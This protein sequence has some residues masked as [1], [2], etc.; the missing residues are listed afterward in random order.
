MP[1]SQSRFFCLLAAALLLPPG[2]AAAQSVCGPVPAANAVVGLAALDIGSN[3]TAN[4][5]AVARGVFQQDAIAPSGALVT[6]SLNLP[7]L[8]P[9]AFPAINFGTTNSSGPDIAAGT[10]NT[11]TVSGA[12]TR[13]TG[14]GTYRIGN[15]TLQSGAAA[16]FAPGEYFVN[17][18]TTA[19]GVSLSVS[20]PGVVR[21]YI[22][23]ALDIGNNSF[24]NAG[25]DPRNMQF[26]LYSPTLARFGAANSQQSPVS[27]VVYSPFSTNIQIGNNTDFTGAIVTAGTV[28]LGTRVNLIY[29]SAVQAA[30]AEVSSCALPPVQPSLASRFVIV[31]DG[32]GINC[33]AEPVTV[34]AVDAAGAVVT[35]YA[36][37]VTL[38]TST[39]RGTWSLVTGAGAFS[40]AT[41]DDG[42]ATYAFAAADRGQAAFTLYAPQGGATDIDASDG[43]AADNDSEGLLAFRPYGFLITPAPVG[44]RVAGRPFNL[45][46][47]AAGQTRSDPQCGVIEA[48]AG[49]RTLAFWSEYVNPATGTR[50]VS[51]NGV[52]AATSSAAATPQNVTF[53]AG[54]ASIAASY[55]DAGSLRLFVR[56]DAGIGEPPAGT[57]GEIIDEVTNVLGA[58]AAF[59]VRPFGLHVAATGNPAATG[60]TGPRF[61][62][63]GE[64]FDVTATGKVWAAADDANNDG[65][66]DGHTDD[67]PDNNASLADNATTPNFGLATP[68]PTVGRSAVLIDPNPN[69]P[70]FNRLGFPGILFGPTSTAYASGVVTLRNLLYTDVGIIELQATVNNY[71]STG[72]AIHGRSG[73]VGRFYPHQIVLQSAS[74]TP[75]CGGFTYMDQPALGVAFA[76]RATSTNIYAAPPQILFNYHAGTGYASAVVGLAAENGNAG[77][78]LG[79]RLSFPAPTWDRGSYTVNTASAA[80]ARAAAPDGPFE[81]LILGARILSERDN[82]PLQNR[83]MNPATTGNC[84]TTSSCTARMLS[85]AGTRLRYG[86][87]VADN[88]QGS[89]LVPLPLPLRAEYFD[90]NG[91]IVNVADNC[92]PYRA[93]NVSFVPGSYT[94]GLDPGETAPALATDPGALSSGQ[95]SAT[96]ALRLTAPGAGNTGSVGFIYDAPAWLHFDWN[97]VDEGNDGNLYDD[98]PG[99]RATFG[100]FRGPERLIYRRELY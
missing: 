47:T 46:L 76:L 62:K 68:S 39:N 56:D 28:T 6:L 96:N 33:L 41:P 20:P 83:D 55:P 34:R 89:E 91:Y 70:D 30:V 7:G 60:P 100:V 92:T 72:E 22:N 99:G 61:R 77:V 27:A 86:R 53:T 98:D 42:R 16:Q 82:T 25:G 12:S 93:A 2:L 45:T 87:L 18:L 95:T 74:V 78:D 3:V 38:T 43:Q 10:Y 11:V 69:D 4:G 81:D 67:N 35:A 9:T 51:V 44:T 65:I 31:H 36:G 63:A 40:D 85:A 57:G 17:Q 66:P 97:G 59:V 8:Q 75:Y 52:N 21:F 49:A 71:L 64:V 80:F 73:R 88:A 79:P 19:G 29:T 5:N 13:F 84:A 1:R 23:G 24:V 15:L 37:T 58:T 90:G 94:D 32:N 54:T 26:F 14:G 48:Y 50:Q